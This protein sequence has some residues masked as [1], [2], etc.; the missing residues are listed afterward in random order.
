MAER[1]AA[2]RVE[3][4]PATPVPPRW[5][6]ERLRAEIPASILDDELRV[7][8]FLVLWAAGYESAQAWFLASRSE[9]DV[10][11]LWSSAGEPSDLTLRSMVLGRA[12]LEAVAPASA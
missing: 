1:S 6:P 10:R 2:R 12:N 5:L 4:P 11:D 8:V 3:P 7:R 9:G